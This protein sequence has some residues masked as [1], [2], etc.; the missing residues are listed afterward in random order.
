MRAS[1]ALAT[2]LTV[3]ATLAVPGA[4]AAHAPPGAVGGAPIAHRSVTTDE[5]VKTRTRFFGAENVDQRT[6]AVRRDRAILSWFGVTNFAL[7]IRGHVV[8]LDA[9]VPRGAHSRLRADDA[10][11]ARAA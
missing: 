5:L 10:R 3:G 2:T 4:A 8:L 9:W 11:G 7:A 6:G 1:R